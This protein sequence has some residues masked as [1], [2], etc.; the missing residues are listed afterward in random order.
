MRWSWLWLLWLVA[1]PAWAQAPSREDRAAAVALF[2][3]AKALMDARNY[4]EACPKFARALELAHGVGIQL[5]LALCYEQLGKLAS[6][7]THHLQVVAETE[8]TRDDPVAMKRL[9][10]ARAH[11]AALEPR[12]TRMVVRVQAPVPGLSLSRDDLALDPTQWGVP[13]PVDPAEY[14]VVARAPGHVAWRQRV[15]AR[16]AGKQITVVVPPLEPLP[17]ATGYYAGAAVLGGVGVIGIGVGTVA[18]ILALDKRAEADAFCPSDDACYTPGAE[19]VADATT[20]A[21]VSTIGFAVGGAALAAGLVVLLLSPGEDSE[22]SA[23][24]TPSG[25]ALRVRY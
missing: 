10:L 9:E 14:Q 5:N 1:T 18:G 13:I 6:A 3:E 7:W 25:A 17:D 11:V 2:E 19:L 12:L 8:R 16:G 22:L 21:H 15:D 4:A 23:A 24:L 20:L